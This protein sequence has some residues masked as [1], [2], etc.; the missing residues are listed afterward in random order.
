MLS[1]S[2]L[3]VEERR[4]HFIHSLYPRLF[5]PYFSKLSTKVKLFK[6]E[7]NTLIIYYTPFFSFRKNRYCTFKSGAKRVQFHCGP[8]FHTHYLMGIKSELNYFDYVWEK[9]YSLSDENVFYTKPLMK[10]LI[11]FIYFYLCLIYL[12]LSI[13]WDFTSSIGLL[14]E[15]KKVLG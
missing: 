12:Y 2:R 9:F 1:Y 15:Q 14:F 3:T 6:E 7:K 11:I 4:A 10:W 8:I 5:R 13:I